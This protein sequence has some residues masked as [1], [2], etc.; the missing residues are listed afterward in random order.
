[1]DAKL[2][3]KIEELTIHLIEIKKDVEKQK[4]DF[5]KHNAVLVKELIYWRPIACNTQISRV[6]MFKLAC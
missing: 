5:Y 6:W 2:W 3:E 1:M 4:I